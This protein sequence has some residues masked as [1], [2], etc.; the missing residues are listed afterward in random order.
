MND[1]VITYM[2]RNSEQFWD[3]M[4]D[5]GSLEHYANE[6]IADENSPLDKWNILIVDG[7]ANHIL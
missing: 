7:K 3:I 5:L 6:L 2:E 1:E 4:L